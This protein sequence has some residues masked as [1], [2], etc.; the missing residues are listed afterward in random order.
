M[1]QVLLSVLIITLLSDIPNVV[2]DS[3]FNLTGV[4]GSTSPYYTSPGHPGNNPH[5]LNTYYRING[6]SSSNVITVSFPFFQLEKHRLCNFDSL[7]IYEGPTTTARLIGKYC[8]TKSFFT[9]TG[10]GQYMYMNYRTDR[11]IHSIGFRFRFSIAASNAPSCDQLSIG[12][13]PNSGNITSPNYPLNY[14]HNTDCRYR[15]NAGS[16]TRI[17]TLL[18][19]AFNLESHIDCKYDFVEV[20]TGF[21]GN[22]SP[23]SKKYCGSAVPARQVITGQQYV[24]IR[25]FADRSVARSGFQMRYIISGGGS[26]DQ[27]HLGGEPG[28]NG[29]IFSPNHPSD[30]PK[31]I[32]CRYKVSSSCHNNTIHFTFNAFNIE[33]N[34]QCRWDYVEMFSNCTVTP[35]SL[36]RYCGSN[37][38]DPITRRTA[39]MSMKFK[40]DSSVTMSGF[41]ITYTIS[42][43]CYGS[44]GVISSPSYPMNYPNFAQNNYVVKPPNATLIRLG[45]NDFDMEGT[46]SNNCRFDSLTIRQGNETGPILS[47][48]CG[49]LGSFTREYAATKLTLMFKTDRSVTR[50]G[51][52]CVYTKV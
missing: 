21:K 33:R 9:V 18:F 47:K 26:C 45:F 29:V 41:N 17:I 38:P 37:V 52:Q 2:A 1:K 30:Y 40:T 46:E 7:A 6:R 15:I 35:V 8:G 32:M 13:G 43:S 39:C 10:R 19:T 49:F 25:F 4:V 44:T 27:L 22:W 48:F 3:L 23:T 20:H 51:F 28:S 5:N 11:N 34:A 12:G 36:G 50:R 24:Y 16:A 14:P 42:G 31:N